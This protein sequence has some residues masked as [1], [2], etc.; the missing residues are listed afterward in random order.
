VRLKL[1]Y[2]SHLKFKHSKSLLFL[3]LLLMSIFANGQLSKDIIVI[4]ATD[5][6]GNVG[7][8]EK[9][10]LGLNLPEKVNSAINDFITKRGDQQ[11]NPFDPEQIDVTATFISPDRKSIK[12]V[13]GFYYQQFKR[14]IRD[15]DR[16]L[17]T[18]TTLSWR[19][20][21]APDHLGLWS[22]SV[23]VSVP[24]FKLVEKN[25]GSIEFICVA[26]TNPGY[27]EVGQDGKHLRFS[28]SKKSFFAIGQNIAWPRELGKNWETGKVSTKTFAEHLKMVKDL[29]DNSGN[30]FR[31]IMASWGHGIEWEVLGNYYGR[32]AH[33]WELDKIIDVAKAKGLYMHLC[34]E[35][36]VGYR[37]ASNGSVPSVWG[38]E[39]NPYN[40]SSE[41]NS[42]GFAGV[43]D[44]IDALN[45][46][47]AKKYFKRRL[48]YIIARW[49]YS[50]N[51]GVLEFLNEQDGW[52]NFHHDVGMHRASI[53]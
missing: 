6:N 52:H 25:V 8:F 14:D 48:R 12:V 53:D 26:S 49:G 31:L 3:S 1:K 43:L 13:H 28:G 35:M 34:L 19:I 47:N 20:R 16:W 27:L 40:S 2:S 38:W 51:L 18:K 39:N 36:H 30:Y 17:N 11:I 45:S 22:C 44:P 23:T 33:A 32:L 9:L 21:F 5:F 42:G 46:Q 7:K 4:D 29:G 24:A 37:I 50:T 15:A 41:A 10:E